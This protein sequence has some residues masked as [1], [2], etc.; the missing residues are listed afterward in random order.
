MDDD[1]FKK[2]LEDLKEVQKAANSGDWVMEQFLK[3]SYPNIPR[4]EAYRR[5]RKSEQGN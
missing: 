5:L 3:N 1:I 4:K 2:I